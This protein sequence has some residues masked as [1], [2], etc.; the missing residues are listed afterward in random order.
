[1]VRDV[2]SAFVPMESGNEKEIKIN[3]RRIEINNSKT[4]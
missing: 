3:E 4:Y 1:M 2:L